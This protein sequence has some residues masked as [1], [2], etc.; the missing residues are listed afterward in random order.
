M[1]KEVNV[2]RKTAELAKAKGFDWETYSYY[3]KL[4]PIYTEVLQNWNRIDNHL[5]APTQSLLQKWLRDKY[6]IDLQP[7]LIL[8]KN[9]TIEVKQEK[10]SKEYAYML[11][12]EGILNDNYTIV[13]FNSYEEALEVGLLEALKLITI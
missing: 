10:E 12:I 9:N 6:N 13:A 4:E 8:C 2:S 11:F 3:Y 7:Y 5:S 1:S